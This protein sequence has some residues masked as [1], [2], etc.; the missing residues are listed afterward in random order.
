MRVALFHDY[1]NQFGGGERVFKVLT[2][3]FPRADIYTLLYDKEKTFGIFEGNGRIRTSFL[4]HPFVRSHHRGFIPLMPLASGLMHIENDYDLVVSSSSGYA[5]GFGLYRG[6]GKAYH[7]CYCHSPLR[8]AWEIDYL[9]N[10]PFAPHLM[11]RDPLRLAAKWFRRWDKR[12][13]ERVNLFVANSNFIAE[14]IRSYYERDADV[15]YPPVSLRTFYHEPETAEG[16]YYLMVGRLLY[17]KGFD[18]GIRAFSRMKKRLVVIGRGPEE[19]KLRALADPNYITFLSSVS[20]EGLRHYYN[21]ARALIFPQIEDFGLV[22]AEAQA[23]GTPVLAFAIG[24]GAEIVEDGSTGILFREQSVEAIV[25]AVRSA[26]QKR[27][28]RKKIAERAGRFS[29]ELFKQSL[30]ESIRRSGFS[31]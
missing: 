27:F 13:S 21:G 18:L 17:Y 12:A 19:K 8:Y 11:S 9:K 4:D 26:E 3:M 31:L 30:L 1:L 10:L 24:G 5:K 23:C 7:V 16:N 22:A 29:E 15:V 2:G 14:K 28:N 25:Q 20:D 6:S